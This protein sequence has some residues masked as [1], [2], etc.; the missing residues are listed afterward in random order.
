MDNRSSYVVICPQSLSCMYLVAIVWH[1]SA[2][3]NEMFSNK[4]PLPK[5]S[6]DFIDNGDTVLDFPPEANVS[7][8]SSSSADLILDQTET[9]YIL[10]M[11]NDSVMLMRNLCL[12]HL[13]SVLKM[14]LG[15]KRMQTSWISSSFFRK[16]M[17]LFQTASSMLSLCVSLTWRNVEQTSYADVMSQSDAKLW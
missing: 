10:Q 4:C 2:Q 16:S 14:V 9:H 12:K 3:N 6:P 17:H 13:L 1:L 11:T 5:D 7:D 15:C 8:I